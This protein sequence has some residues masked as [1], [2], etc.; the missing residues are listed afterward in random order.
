[1]AILMREVIHSLKTK[2]L[3]TVADQS[4]GDREQQSKPNN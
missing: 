3:K 2:V 4:D 1:M